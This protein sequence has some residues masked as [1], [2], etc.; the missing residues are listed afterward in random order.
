MIAG[1]GDGSARVKLR[2]AVIL[3]LVVVA[4]AAVASWYARQV[5]TL[6]TVEVVRGESAEAVYATGVVEPRHWAMVTSLIRERIVEECDCEGQS[7]AAGAVLA[8]VH[9]QEAQAAL[10]ELQERL[11]LAE[12]EYRRLQAMAAQQAAAAQEVDRARTEVT[13]LHALVGAQRV[14]IDNHVLRSP[15]DGVVLRREAR[16]GEIAEPGAALF[17]VGQPRPLVIIAEVNE[18]DIPR[19]AVG[20]RALIRSDAFADCDFESVVDNITLQGDP[21]TRTYRVRLRLPDDTPLMIGMS[22]DVNVIVRVVRDALIVPTLA[23]QGDWVVVVEEGTARRRQIHTGIRGLQAV[24][25]VS[26]LTEGTRIISPF[27]QGLPEGAP[28]KTAQE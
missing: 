26:G 17:W 22:V 24:E 18:E 10:V 19:V 25:V 13:R 8:R 9:D 2:H 4:V 5:P 7:V 28:V 15:M 6:S 21:V 11:Q 27:P 23:L 16:V 1:R 3:V 20:Q 12:Q 14:R